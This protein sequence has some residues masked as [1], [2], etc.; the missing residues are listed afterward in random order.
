MKTITRV[1]AVLAFAG[2]AGSVSATVA[3][4]EDD[5]VTV[6]GT[7]WVQVDLFTN[8]SWNDINAACPGGICTGELNS[9]GVHGLIWASQDDLNKLFNVYLIEANV[10]EHLLLGPTRHNYSEAGAIE[11]VDDFLS[12]G[13]R[14]TYSDSEQEIVDGRLSTMRDPM[15]G[16]RASFQ[17]WVENK[18]D[19]FATNFTA[20]VT[21]SWS[22]TGAW[23]YLF[24]D[25]DNDGVS[26]WSDNCPSIP[27]E[28]QANSDGVTDGGDACDLDDDND[29]IPDDNPDNCRTAPN[30]DQ[31]D[32]D[33][34]GF[35]DACDNCMSIANPL[36]EPSA[37]N[38]DCGEAC[39]TGGCGG[40]RCTNH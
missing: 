14:I 32:S 37:L 17:N 38:P 20:P 15:Y 6:D 12:D 7:D 35:G 25:T 39:E 22:G 28:D 19:F 33:G 10:A 31:T 2:W 27:N 21:S 16:Y 4:S 11:W 34:D 18:V 13:W 36:Q 24:V 23:F 5:I 1:L 26:D 9:Y 3:I 8:L 29:G 30:T 40:P